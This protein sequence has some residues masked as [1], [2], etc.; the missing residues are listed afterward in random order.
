[1][2]VIDGVV[3]PGGF[4]YVSPTGYRV[5]AQ[6]SAANVADL[7]E[8]LTKYRLENHLDVG[9]PSADVESY[10]CSNYPNM[11]GVYDR[12]SGIQTHGVTAPFL[13]R[14]VDLV[15]SWANVLMDK[16]AKVELV[17]QA[18]ADQRSMA[19]RKCI[20]NQEWRNGCGPCVSTAQRGLATIRQGRDVKEPDQMLY[21][22]LHRI[23]TRTAVWLDRKTFGPVNAPSY[24]FLA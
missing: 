21:C 14:A 6:D 2:P 17:P 1:M 13:G 18:E 24:C 3:P 11:C 23:D 8:K 20:Y 5:P 15:N 10:I 4:S 12:A 9:N 22:G 7:V 19:C 16:R